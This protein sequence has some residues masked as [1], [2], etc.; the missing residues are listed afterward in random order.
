MNFPGDFTEY[1]EHQYSENYKKKSKIFIGALWAANYWL[2][3]LGSSVLFP[4]R[5][6]IFY[7]VWYTL[8]IQLDFWWEVDREA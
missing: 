7:M 5:N 8:C 1:E 6:M 3:P 2:L 4:D